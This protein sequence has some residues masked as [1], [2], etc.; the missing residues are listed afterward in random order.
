[1]RR[2]VV[3]LTLGVLV[4][5]GLP[6]AALLRP[7]QGSAEPPDYGPSPRSTFGLEQA[8]DF[9]DWPLYNL[10][11]SF[12]GYPL[13]AVLRTHVTSPVDPEVTK[14]R[15]NYVSFIYGDCLPV[16]DTGCA[17]LLE[18]QVSPACS[19][20]P[21]DID[22]PDSG[23]A[24]VRG[25]RAV[26]YEEGAKI[27]LVTGRSTV[28]IYGGSRE[29]VVRAARALRGLNVAVEAGASLPEPALDAPGGPPC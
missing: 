5:V 25:V 16:A 19:Y 22:L 4:V 29:Q 26:F 3:L 21:A 12:D 2:I 17:P 24:D 15:P 27:V 18:V 11:A 14:I 10:G 6:L 1:M 20:T 23:V 9:A 28:A 13:V 7:G 8:R